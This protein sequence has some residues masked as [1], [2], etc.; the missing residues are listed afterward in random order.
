M[1]SIQYLELYV[2][3]HITI[4]RG[5]VGNKNAIKTITPA[6]QQSHRRAAKPPIKGHGSGRERDDVLRCMSKKPKYF[7][8]GEDSA[9]QSKVI[10]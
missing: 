7:G 2:R 9:V 1:A 6:A 5:W 3:V 4:I 10:L 8:P